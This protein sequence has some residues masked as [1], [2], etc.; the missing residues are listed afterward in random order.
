MN[1]TIILKIIAAL[2]LI[3]V[4]F[5]ISAIDTNAAPK[6]IPSAK[7]DALMQQ[8]IDKGAAKL[9]VKLDSVTWLIKILKDGHTISFVHVLD[10][11]VLEDMNTQDK[12]L[13]I[14]MQ[15][16]IVLDK[17][18]AQ[19]KGAMA[20]RAFLQNGYQVVLV[21]YDTQLKLIGRVH[22]KD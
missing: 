9:P 18:D 19:E 5:F 10:D 22:F 7:L 17:M 14:E 4:A 20:I 16:E 13:L 12:R 15:K 1:K 21:Y 8:A 11:P 2:T 3:A 6:R